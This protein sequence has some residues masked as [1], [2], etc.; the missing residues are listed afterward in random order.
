MNEDLELIKADLAQLSP[1]ERKHLINQIVSCVNSMTFD[2][3]AQ[4]K[5]AK[6]KGLQGISGNDIV[7]IC[8]QN[9]AAVFENQ[10]VTQHS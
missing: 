9:I 7:Q 6:S 4:D 1:E 3:A 8:D 2:M 10:S 5:V